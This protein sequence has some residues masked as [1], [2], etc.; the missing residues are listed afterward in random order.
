M[1]IGVTLAK[2]PTYYDGEA[3]YL[4]KADED[5]IALNRLI[6]RQ[7]SVEF[8]NQKFCAGC[9]QEFAELFRMGFCKN[10]FFTRP[11]AGESIIRPELSRAHLGEEDRDLAFEKGYQLQPHIVYLANSGGLKVGVTRGRQQWHRWMDQGA[12]YAL[13]FAETENRYQAGQ[14][15]VALK[16]FIGDK[17]PWQRMLKNQV[18][19]IDLP[20]EKERLAAELDKDLSQWVSGH[21]EVNEIHYPVRQYPEKVKSLNLNKNGS[22][23][24]K[25]QGIKGQYWIMEGGNVLNVR[26]HTGFRVRLSLPASSATAKDATD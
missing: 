15:E 13:I 25:L 24:A 10:C 19:A 17:T 14:I 18:E 1:D 7:I 4:L 23:T 16:E 12:S 21:K 3:H 9:G 8:L 6:G 5:F 22:I 11:E 26:S 2:M 20:A